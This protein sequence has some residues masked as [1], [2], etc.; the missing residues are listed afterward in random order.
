VLQA[1]EGFLLQSAG[2]VYLSEVALHCCRTKKELDAITVDEKELEDQ[3]QVHGSYK[4]PELMNL[5]IIQFW[6]IPYYAYKSVAWHVRW[7]RRYQFGNEEYTQEDKEYVV[8]CAS[9]RC[10]GVSLHHVCCVYGSKLY[11]VTSG[12]AKRRARTR[13]ANWLQSY[14]EPKSFEWHNRAITKILPSAF[15]KTAVV[16]TKNNDTTTNKSTTQVLA[17]NAPILEC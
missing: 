3:I 6:F 13:V 5:A 14:S 9:T 8:R 17:R 16:V 12:K 10:C 4:K 11:I 1:D 15:C 2:C 7:L